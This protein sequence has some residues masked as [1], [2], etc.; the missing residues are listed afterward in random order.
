MLF[1]MYDLVLCYLAHY[2]FYC[3]KNGAQ[4]PGEEQQRECDVLCPQQQISLEDVSCN[5]KCSG[6][7]WPYEVH[8]S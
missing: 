4:S 3:S 1:V 5:S 6:G 8:F 7:M 2:F